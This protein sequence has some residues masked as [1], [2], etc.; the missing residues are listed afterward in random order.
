MTTLVDLEERRAA[1][2]DKIFCLLCK[3]KKVIVNTPHSSRS[4]HGGNMQI[5]EAWMLTCELYKIVN[6]DTPK[7]HVACWEYSFNPWHVVFNLTARTQYCF[8]HVKIRP[9]EILVEKDGLPCALLGIDYGAVLL[10]PDIREGILI[11]TLRKEIKQKQMMLQTKNF[12][13]ASLEKA[14]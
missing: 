14:I 9:F 8:H 13:C 3:R 5:C 7:S 11:A 4:I 12:P 2:H 10:S 6:S 1:L